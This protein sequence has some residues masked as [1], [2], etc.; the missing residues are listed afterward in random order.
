MTARYAMYDV[1]M[2]DSRTRSLLGV[3]RS[4]RTAKFIAAAAKEGNEPPA[5]AVGKGA[6][7]IKDDVPEIA[8]AGRSNVGRVRSSMRYR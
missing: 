2:L 7:K 8:F 4:K 5:H 3:G 6:S 1:G